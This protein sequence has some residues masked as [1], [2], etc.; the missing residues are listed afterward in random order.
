MID[1]MSQGLAPT[2][3]QGLFA[4][5]RSLPEQGVAVLIVEQ[6]VTHALAVASRAYVLE[7]GEV[8]YSGDAAT[9]ARDEGFVKG[10]YLGDGGDGAGEG[11]GPANGSAGLRFGGDAE[12]GLPAD[13]LRRIELR[14]EE[15]GRNPAEVVLELLREAIEGPA[16]KNHG[17]GKG[18]SS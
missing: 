1:E 7:K 12:T 15:E 2:I 18:G 17:N 3:V 4:I 6:F 13:L 16:T 9:L 11:E 8:A 5:V 14:A 10:S